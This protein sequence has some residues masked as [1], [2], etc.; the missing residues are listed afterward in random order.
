MRK[1]K[2]AREGIMNA[3]DLGDILYALQSSERVLADTKGEE[4]TQGDEDKLYNFKQVAK[5]VR[6]KCP[7]CGKTAS[8]S[9]DVV[10][11][12]F[13]LKHIFA[14][15]DFVTSHET[16]SEEPISGRICDARL[17]LALVQAILA[18]SG[19]C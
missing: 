6:V 10:C 19:Q 14:I 13:L 8:L 7:H 2:G 4:Y 9:P 5:M 1:E 17:Y 11:I 15:L 12:V 18:E 3:S 16:K